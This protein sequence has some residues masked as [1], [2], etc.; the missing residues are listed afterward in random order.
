MALFRRDDEH[1]EDDPLNGPRGLVNGAWISLL[2]WV[3]L[4][5]MGIVLWPSS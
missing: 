5:L 4:F 2:L 3:V 1:R